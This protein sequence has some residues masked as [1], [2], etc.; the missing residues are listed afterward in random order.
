MRCAKQMVVVEGEEGGERVEGGQRRGKI[1]G[2]EKKIRPSFLF[3]DVHY[4]DFK[5]GFGYEDTS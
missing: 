5:E 3:A 4:L 1:R 2:V